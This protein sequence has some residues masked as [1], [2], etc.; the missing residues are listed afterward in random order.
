MRNR[1]P[2]LIRNLE[3]KNLKLALAESV[4]CGLAAHKLCGAKGTSEVLAGSVVCY[5]PETKMSLL[6]VSQAMINR[7]TCESMRVTEALAKNLPGVIKADIYAAVTGLASPGG[8]ET[9]EKPVGTVFFC[10]YYQ[11][12]MFRQKKLF[13]GSPLQVRKKACEELY[14]MIL[15]DV[16]GQKPTSK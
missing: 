10:V 1:V 6:G 14:R 11:R 16:V 9:K 4:T 7:Y 13:R 3:E 8:S 5:S 15:S 2:E 12:K